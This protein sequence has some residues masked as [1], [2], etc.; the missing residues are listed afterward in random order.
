MVRHVD[1]KVTDLYWKECYRCIRRH[2]PNNPILIIDDASDSQFLNEDLCVHHCTTIFHP[3][4]QKGRG[5]WLGWY[6]F[7]LLHPFETAVILHDS[8][9]I[10]SP[11]LDKDVVSSSDPI[12][13]LWE[14]EDGEYNYNMTFTDV[15][16]LLDTCT[17]DSDR[18]T[19]LYK[20]HEHRSEWKGCFGNMAI[21]QWTVLPELEHTYGFMTRM[22]EHVTSRGL[23]QGMERII[24]II[25]CDYLGGKKPPSVLGNILTYMPWGG[26][27]MDYCT[28]VENYTQYP[29]VKVWTGR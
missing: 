3:S 14:F 24:G 7:Y 29:I 27:F 13:F 12:C 19:R 28:H 21:V 23:R 5:E 6:Y 17:M 22:M 25:V 8:V 1:R 4:S 11:V 26:S 20:L 9:F 18:R 15:R 2:Y 16:R 10:Q